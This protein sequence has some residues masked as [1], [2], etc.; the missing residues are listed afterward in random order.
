MADDSSFNQAFIE[1]SFILPYRAMLQEPSNIAPANTDTMA[2][3]PL[4]DIKQSAGSYYSDPL[5]QV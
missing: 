3:T 2:L 1:R 5:C 4:V